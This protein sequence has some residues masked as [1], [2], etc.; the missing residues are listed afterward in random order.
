MLTIL[1]AR[2]EASIGS[3]EGSGSPIYQV[4][5]TVSV[6]RVPRMGGGKRERFG[7]ERLGIGERPSSTSVSPRSRATA[8]GQAVSPRRHRSGS[9][10]G[11]AVAPPSRSRGSQ[12]GVRL[13]RVPEPN[14]RRDEEDWLWT[15]GVRDYGRSG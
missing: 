5:A 8:I 10:A 11:R 13:A 3:P 15:I 14:R 7:P 4:A 1:L 2:S 9:V 12:V 6:R